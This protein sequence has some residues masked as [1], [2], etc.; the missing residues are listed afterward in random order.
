MAAFRGEVQVRREAG[1]VQWR[2]RGVDRD[3]GGAL[4][5]L[6]AGAARIEWP[7]RLADAELYAHGEPGAVQWELSS[8]AGVQPIVAR[9]VQVHRGA[10]AAFERALPRIV[11]PFSVRAGWM[12]LLE[13]LR[14]PGMLRLLQRARGG[15]AAP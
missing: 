12:L 9:A 11:A 15:G 7:A 8:A 6:F 5:L 14:V 4:E 2:L 10:A 1:A 3:G 13:A